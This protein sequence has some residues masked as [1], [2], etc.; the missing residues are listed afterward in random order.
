[1]NRVSQNFKILELLRLL[2]PLEITHD[3]IYCD[4]FQIELKFDEPFYGIAYADFDRASACQ[5]SGRGNLTARLDLPLKG[6]GTKQV[7]YT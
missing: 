3:V 6:C 7:Q 5:V 4:F 1:M 2:Q